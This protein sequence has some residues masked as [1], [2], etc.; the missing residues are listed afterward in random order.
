MTRLNH[1][2]HLNERKILLW[3]K[4]SNLFDVVNDTYAPIFTK[5]KKKKI[6]TIV[7]RTN[8]FIMILNSKVS[9]FIIDFEMT[10]EKI[11]LSEN[12]NKE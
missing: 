3:P 12:K 1:S 9:L 2:A 11:L 7:F 4:N 10:L 5:K 8:Y 6:K